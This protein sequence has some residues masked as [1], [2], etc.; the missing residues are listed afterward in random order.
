MA[1]NLRSV[2][3]KAPSSGT[4]ASARHWFVPD[5]GAAA[6]E[7]SGHTIAGSVPSSRLM[8]SAKDHARIR[9]TIDY[10]DGDFRACYTV[11]L[12]AGSY[13]SGLRR[14]AA[15]AEARAWLELEAVLHGAELVC[16]E[17]V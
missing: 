12:G 10:I 2:R 6:Q 9:A 4:H 11:S 8:P 7:A 13:R 3:L 14:F 15:L 5:A 16:E 1:R 17:Q